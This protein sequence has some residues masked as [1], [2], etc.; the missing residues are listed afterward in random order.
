MGMKYTFSFLT[1]LVEE[2]QLTGGKLK[3]KKVFAW[4]PHLVHQPPL[5]DASDHP[6]QM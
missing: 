2:K 3:Q 5:E 1:N 4:A 6:I